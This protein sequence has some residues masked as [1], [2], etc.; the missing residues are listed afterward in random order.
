V[1]YGEGTF[2]AIN[3]DQKAAYS[4]DGGLTWTETD[5]PL[6][7]IGLAAG[8]LAYGDGK[9]VAGMGNTAAYSLDKGKTWTATSLASNFSVGGIAYGN[10][11]FVAVSREAAAPCTLTMVFTGSRVTHRLL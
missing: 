1:A 11:K 2:V 9:F 10:G 3:C 4:A 7:G 6:P 5:L 8:G